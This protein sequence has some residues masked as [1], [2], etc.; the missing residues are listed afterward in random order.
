MITNGDSN[1]KCDMFNVL[2]PYNGEI[3]GSVVDSTTKDIHDILEKSYNFNC[4]MSVEDRAEILNKTADYLEDNLNELARLITLESGLCLKDTQYEVLRVVNCA[5]YSAKVCAIVERD[6]T[7]DFVLDSENKPRLEVISEP[8][9]LIIAITPF[10]HPMNQVAHKIFPAIAAGASIVLKPSE[11]TP[12]SAIKLVEI[13]IEN[14]LPSNMVNIITVKDA[15]KGLNSILSFPHIDM[16]TFTGGLSA[17]L[18]IKK[19]MVEHGHGLKRYVPELGGCS[20]IIICNDADIDLSANIVING[21]FKNSGQ[22]CTAIR[23]VVVDQSIADKF[24]DNLLSKVGLLSYGKPTDGVDMGT[25]VDEESAKNIENR[26]QSAV[27]SGAK[28][29][30]GGNRNGAQLSPTI[31]DDV[32]LSM[33]LVALETFGPVCSII[34]VANFDEALSVAKQTNYRLAGAIVTTDK[35]KAKRAATELK[36]GQFNVNGPPGYRTEAA[37]FGGFGD[38]GNGEKEGV[39]L[40]AYGMRRIRT[41]YEHE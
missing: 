3:V 31:L 2:N 22:R 18:I 36:V 8:L 41:S 28:I 4:E 40:A 10:N 33:D 15:N 27:S 12:L 11:K 29:L 1:Y 34:R 17:G 20:S 19:A 6:I 21:C 13:L 38:S 39:I 24:V 25:V 9:D 26:I 32:T 7:D 30:F 35:R 5:R 16:V 14:G 37:P 23:R